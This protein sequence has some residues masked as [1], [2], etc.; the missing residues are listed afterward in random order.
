MQQN[1]ISVTSRLA[2]TPFCDIKNVSELVG[3]RI[4][5][6]DLRL[7]MQNKFPYI[8]GK[9]LNR[10]RI[11]QND[12]NNF[13]LRQTKTRFIWRNQGTMKHNAASLMLC[14]IFG[15]NYVSK[16]GWNM[17]QNTIS[18]ISRL[19]L[20]PFCD[21]KNVSELVGDRIWREDLRPCMRNKF[22]YNC[23]GSAVVYDDIQNSADE[24]PLC[25]QR[26]TNREIRYRTDS[27]IKNKTM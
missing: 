22:P 19:G 3:D 21:I 14:C 12:Q 25:I 8:Y 20:T 15:L 13:I 7:C 5:G 23:G 26:N 17:Q 9:K 6:G 1:T 24:S 11:V 4:W 2:L 16:W 18:V 10:F 27:K